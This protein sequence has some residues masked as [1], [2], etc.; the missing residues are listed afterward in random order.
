MRR[1]QW[2]GLF[3]I[4]ARHGDVQARSQKYAPSTL[5][6][7]TSASIAVSAGRRVACR[8]AA[9]PIA[10]MKQADHPAANN[11]SGF[12]PLPGA[13]GMTA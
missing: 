2:I 3:V 1:Q 4:D 9:S 6:K 13:P 7:S 5:H 12:V 11:C 10:P 8:A